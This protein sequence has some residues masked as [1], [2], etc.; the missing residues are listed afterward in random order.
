MK[1]KKKIKKKNINKI[2]IWMLFAA[3]YFMIVL[4]FLFLPIKDFKQRKS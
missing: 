2:M 4:N 1:N 3:S